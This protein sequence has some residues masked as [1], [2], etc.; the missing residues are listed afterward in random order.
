LKA[1]AE[2]H[3]ML[4]MAITFVVLLTGLL[5]SA[6]AALRKRRPMPAL[7]VPRPS[8]LRGSVDSFALPTTA[9][10]FDNAPSRA[11]PEFPSSAAL[12]RRNLYDLP[13]GGAQKR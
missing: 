5:L 11:P 3:I 4:P 2:I 12:R 9:G 1:L 6:I 13:G 8:R 7:I 10:R